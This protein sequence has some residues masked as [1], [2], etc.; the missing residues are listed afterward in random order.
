MS[1]PEA[2]QAELGEF[3]PALPSCSIRGFNK[4]GEARPHGG[5]ICSTQSAHP[6]ADLQKHPH[7]HTQ[8]QHSTTYLDTPWLSQV[9][10]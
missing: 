10:T 8:K 2:H 9:D 1:Q 5:M 7:R 3:S 4:E 6:D